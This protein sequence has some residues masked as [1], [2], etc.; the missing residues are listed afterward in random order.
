MIC[1]HEWSTPEKPTKR[2]RLACW[3]VGCSWH[4][5][6]VEWFLMSISSHATSGLLKF[7]KNLT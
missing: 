2:V 4:P 1:L 6:R 5:S 3:F 7:R